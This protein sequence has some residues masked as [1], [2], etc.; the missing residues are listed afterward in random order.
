MRKLFLWLT[1]LAL[2]V[3][4]C[5]ASASV[6]TDLK[7]SST[8]CVT[9]G[10]AYLRD[11]GTPYYGEV[12]AFRNSDYY[13]TAKTTEDVSW[14]K[15]PHGS[16]TIS[17]KGDFVGI[18]NAL[19]PSIISDDGYSIR[20]MTSAD[21]VKAGTEIRYSF[22]EPRG[23]YY[24]EDFSGDYVF[25][26]NLIASDDENIMVGSHKPSSV[27]TPTTA[28]EIVPYIE[29]VYSDDVNYI[30]GINVYFVRSNDV[31][32]AVDAG[33]SKL[34]VSTYQHSGD[35]AYFPNPS[36]KS[37]VS[38]NANEYGYSRI[39]TVRV[40]YVKG[41]NYYRWTF[42]T[43]DKVKPQVD[44]GD[45][46]LD[47]GPLVIAANSSKDIV[48]KLPNSYR[49][50][51]SIDENGNLVTFY[52]DD[53]YDRVSRLESDYVSVGN[54]DVLTLDEGT[55]S[56]DKGTG[57][58]WDG[59]TYNENK[60]EMKF[61]LLSGK[62]GK[63]TLI[64]N[65]PDGGTYYR[66]VHVGTLP[67]TATDTSGLKLNIASHISKARIFD[68]KPYYPSSEFEGIEIELVSEDY[69][70]YSHGYFGV[71]DGNVSEIHGAY[72]NDRLG[73]EGV[74][75]NKV[76]SSDNSESSVGNL[77]RIEDISNSSVW[78]EFEDS[79]L[80]LVSASLKSK[81]RLPQNVTVRTTAEQLKDFVPYF[82]FTDDTTIH[83]SF[84]D[85]D[86]KQT[87]PAI[88]DL[89]INGTAIDDG[90]TSGDLE[91]DNSYHVEF[92]YDYNELTYV[93]NFEKMTYS[94]YLYVPNVLPVNESIEG[95]FDVY[96][97]VESVDLMV[98]DET[99]ASVSPTTFTFTDISYNYQ[100]EYPE[101]DE[102]SFT[103]TGKKVGE[104][105]L[106]LL[107]V[108]KDA[109]PYNKYFQAWTL[110]N[111]VSEETQEKIPTVDDS[112]TVTLESS[113][114][115]VKLA[116][117]RANI[118]L[119]EGKPYYDKGKGDFAISI[120][121][122]KMVSSDVY[123]NDYEV[124][125]SLNGYLYMT[126]GDK[127][128]YYYLSHRT[129]RDADDE[130]FKIYYGNDRAY[131]YIPE[132]ITRVSWDF[133]C[134]ANIPGSYDIPSVRK[135]SQQL[136][137]YKPYVQ[138]NRDGINVKSVEY[139]FVDGSGNKIATPSS[140]SNVHVN[141]STGAI[142]SI[143]EESSYGSR[144]YKEFSSDSDSGMILVNVPEVL[145]YDI[146]F[147]FEEDGV[148][149]RWIFKVESSSSYSSIVS[150]DAFPLVI[151]VGDTKNLTFNIPSAD[152]ITPVVGNSAIA[153]L[154]DASASTGSTRTVSLKGVAA[155]MTTISAMYNIT[156]TK[157]TE[158]STSQGLTPSRE[159]WV[160]SRNAATGKYVV[161]GLTDDLEA[162]MT[163]I[164][165]ET[166]DYNSSGNTTP[167]P[168]P[169]SDSNSDNNNGNVQPD[170]ET[171]SAD[172]ESPSEAMNP[173]SPDVQQKVKDSLSKGST[174]MKEIL[175]Q[176]PDLEVVDVTSDD[177]AT[178][179][180]TT[181]SADI[182]S[183]YV[184]SNR[185]LA[186]TLNRLTIRKAKIFM[187]R[188]DLRHLPKG[189]NLYWILARILNPG[190]EV[191]SAVADDQSA[192]F[193]DENGNEIT[194]SNAGTVNVAAYIEPGSYI[195]A[196][197]SD[198][199]GTPKGSG[200]SSGGCN[201]FAFTGIALLG[202]LFIKGKSK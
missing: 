159:I 145:V 57:G 90:V 91:L 131:T 16:L 136:S 32:T 84:V 160:A 39:E 41:G 104:T 132:N 151:Y 68:G 30:Q 18:R 29:A 69:Y 48:I 38:F 13:L 114:L 192:V 45:L 117:A 71:T 40:D 17:G 123:D 27:T 190:A 169:D 194:A 180:D 85:K 140:V 36:G 181:T 46:A 100:H 144:T 202:L 197:A 120:S 128:M 72:V 199:P 185:K 70:G 98:G 83:W 9:S 166:F 31:K 24:D 149:Y 4:P 161:P 118:P 77:I 15:I 133:P 200:S 51:T 53:E 150:W 25:V 164:M 135:Y 10:D 67:T 158:T 55:L 7:V 187:F 167:T 142:E 155:G 80:N 1:L 119:F 165:Y 174:A 171:K 88:K 96:Y 195:P 61:K 20:S 89:H 103:V 97:D 111:V 101:N 172:M 47:K 134:E 153:S 143:V 179:G 95:Y 175:T 191:S 141:V 102:N 115:N 59:L 162:L 99:I 188:V 49:L 116:F 146:D 182:D 86:G 78:W 177:A 44:F 35:V 110:I 113:D 2:V 106:S 37:Y 23:N 122:D 130:Y 21:T 105:T 156:Y 54:S 157:G 137:T 60:S 201:G 148:L 168:T 42:R 147:W 14:D 22:S 112:M 26:W 74:R 93:W 66:E 124:R 58:T 76:D 5:S 170:F 152:K 196:I 3:V 189:S 33:V 92:R 81:S 79:K 139:Y 28:D 6:L 127:L 183:S 8:Y 198:A 34:R 62:P 11:R 176:S 121:R 65:V 107:G 82:E 75:Y 126:S 184:S 52:G 108:R 73:S 193:F 178:V 56:F 43:A 94:A 154:N 186:V 138:L 64:I 12:T 63:T 129:S 87:S 173:T 19:T 50:P 125:E 163:K 109:K